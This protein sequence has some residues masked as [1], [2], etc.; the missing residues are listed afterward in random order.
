LREIGLASSNPLILT[1]DAAGSA[2]AT[3]VARGDQLL[4]VRCAA[5]MHGQAEALL[6]MIDDAMRAAGLRP[7]ALDLLAVTTGPGS[8][9]GIRVGVAAAQ[10]IALAAGLPLIG[11]GSFEAVAEVVPSDAIAGGSLLVALEARRTDLFVQLFDSAREPLSEPAA[12]LP[13]NLAATIAQV[14]PRCLAIAGDAA[15]RAATALGR[16]S[17]ASVVE[18]PP[19]V[20]GALYAALRRW[21]EGERGGAVRPRYLRPPDVT[22]TGERQVPG[23]S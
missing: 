15:A 10:G 2:C 23:G 9:T 16:R 20:I 8:F 3:A 22:T 18:S 19:S 13:E 4:A 5:M 21:R 6:P 12:V 14:E 1:I 7:A 11:V 17:G